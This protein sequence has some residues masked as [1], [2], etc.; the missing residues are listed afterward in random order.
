MSIEAMYMK[1]CINNYLENLEDEELL[2]VI[3][4]LLRD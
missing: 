4:E 2:A 3:L 1:I